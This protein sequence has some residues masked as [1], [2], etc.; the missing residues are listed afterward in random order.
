[1]SRRLN[2]Q[3]GVRKTSGFTLL[4]L[5]LVVFIMSVLAFSAVSLTDTMESSQDQYRYEATRNLAIK[6]KDEALLQRIGQDQIRGFV[7]DIGDLPRDMT[8]L[9]FGIID[10]GPERDQRIAARQATPALLTFPNGVSVPVPRA[11]PT[12]N[13]LISLTVSKGFIGSLVENEVEDDKQAT[14]FYI[15]S[16]L[17]LKPG[18]NVYL[19]PEKPRFEDGWSTF[20]GDFYSTIAEPPSDVFGMDDLT[21]G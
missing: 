20:Q 13:P 18:N 3:Y 2:F 16:Y 1:M 11:G 5:L 9:A 4:E 19:G 17:T 14:H 15:G 8:E 10:K 12:T 6:I 21:H 7:A